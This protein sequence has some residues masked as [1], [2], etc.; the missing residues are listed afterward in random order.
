M[1]S[2]YK[3]E[4]YNNQGYLDEEKEELFRELESFLAER[5]ARLVK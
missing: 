1:R 5:G 4:P 3:W 2:Q